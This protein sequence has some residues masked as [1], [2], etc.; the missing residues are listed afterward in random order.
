MDVSELTD[1]EEVEEEEVETPA[2]TWNFEQ[3]G[4]KPESE[5][6]EEIAP[7]ATKKY[8][9]PVRVGFGRR[10]AQPKIDLKSE[11]MFPSIEN[12]EK[13]EKEL[14][15]SEAKKNAE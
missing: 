3:N 8:V 6:A 5:R 12:A 1:E 4:V 9:P 7:Q 13:I 10:I 14:G 11:E 2:K 15:K